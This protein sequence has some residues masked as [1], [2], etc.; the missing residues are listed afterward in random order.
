MML[1]VRVNK[2]ICNKGRTDPSCQRL[3]CTISP[4]KGNEDYREEV[5]D[6]FYLDYSK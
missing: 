5:T 4:S 6:H 2:D 1:K 3:I